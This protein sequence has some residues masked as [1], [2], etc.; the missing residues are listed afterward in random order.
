M[1]T[2]KQ[3]R[4]LKEHNTKHDAIMGQWAERGYQH[5]PPILPSLPDDLRNLQCGAKT[6]AGSACKQKAIYTNGRCKYHGG[7]S[8]GPR[9]KEGKAKAAQNGF[10]PGWSKQSP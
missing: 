7:L 1:S 3:R 6:R 9:T 2:S 5:P 8:T 10:K 4:R